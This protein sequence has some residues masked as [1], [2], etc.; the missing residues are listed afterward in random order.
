L[1]KRVD[2]DEVAGQYDRRYAETDFGGIEAAILRF[3]GTDKGRRVLEVGCGTGH[4]LAILDTHG[5]SVAGVDTSQQ[6]L[7]LARG[8][9]PNTVLKQG[10]AHQLPFDDHSFDRLFCVNA[11][12]H[13]DHKPGFLE[14]ARRVLRAAGGVLV[15]GLDPWT[16]LDRWCVYDFFD[17]ALDADRRRYPSTLEVERWMSAAGFSDC[18]TDLVYHMQ[19]LFPAGEALASGLLQKTTVS[20]LSI[21]NEAEY[22]RGLEKIRQSTAEAEARGE[23]FHL[24]VDLNFYAT[25]GWI[26]RS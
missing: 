12:H 24:V 22:Q 1:R 11:I 18:C 8:R 19:R 7:E 23:P 2:Y 15:V 10:A 20:Q 4:W 16:G 21:L 6:M 17:G 3:A 13:F 25:I 5:F 26:G 14:E 9:V